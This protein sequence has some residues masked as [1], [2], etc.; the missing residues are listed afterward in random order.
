MLTDEE[1][2]MTDEQLLARAR[3]LEALGTAKVEEAN[4][5]RDYFARKLRA[6]NLPPA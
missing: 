5:L 3:E 1:K 2:A 4:E 6:G